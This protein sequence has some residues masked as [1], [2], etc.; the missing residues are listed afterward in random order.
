M[1]GEEWFWGI[2]PHW[3]PFWCQDHGCGE[4]YALASLCQAALSP[5]RCGSC[6]LESKGE[7]LLEP[8]V[9]RKGGGT[10]RQAGGLRLQGHPDPPWL[11]GAGG[12]GR[13]L[14]ESSG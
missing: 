14:L 13:G 8:C 6:V 4:P 5:A 10:K 11:P 7:G 12:G 9:K 1:L 3:G 2:C